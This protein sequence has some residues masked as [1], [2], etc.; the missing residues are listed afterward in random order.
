[1]IVIADT[2]PLSYLV[3]IGEIDVL[4]A[5]YRRIII[6]VFVLDELKHRAAPGVVQQWIAKP[7]AWLDIRVPRI[8]PDPE[9]AELDGGERDAILLAQE[10]GAN[11]LIIDDMD[12]RREAQR[13]KLHF[14]GTLG[15]LRLAADKGLLDFKYAVE[16]LRSTNF[17]VAQDVLNL[18]MKG[19]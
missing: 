15:V 19:D 2:S 17:Y 4:P 9:L 16:R 11:E 13:R 1:M 12:G 5:L 6:T 8:L 18:F 3:R 14:V 7:P 10:L